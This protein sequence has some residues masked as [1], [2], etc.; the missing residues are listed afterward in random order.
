[1]R[2]GEV[3]YLYMAF[4]QIPD[5]T[6]MILLEIKETRKLHNSLIRWFF[7]ILKLK[8]ICVLLA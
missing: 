6:K 4:S 5:I 2:R 3:L 8:M 1:V 7:G